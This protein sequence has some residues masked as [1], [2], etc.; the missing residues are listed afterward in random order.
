MSTGEVYERVSSLDEQGENETQI[1][2]QDLKA[3]NDA[4]QEVITLFDRYEE[5]A[6][7]WDDFEGYVEFQYHNLYMLAF[8][9]VADKPF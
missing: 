7:D 8:G 1:T 6:T 2:E 5:R 3:V 4:Y 9:R